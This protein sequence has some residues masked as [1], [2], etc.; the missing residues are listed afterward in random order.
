MS[1]YD[2]V[3]AK[4]WPT[5]VV[6]SKPYRFASLV[7]V[8]VS[9][10][11][12]VFSVVIISVMMLLLPKETIGHSAAANLSSQGTFIVFFLAVLFVPLYETLI[13]QLIPLELSRLARLNDLGCIVVG[14]AVFGLG[15]Y[16]NGGLLHGISALLGG[17]LFALS[18]IIL[19]PW[20]YL[21]A[22]WASY[23]AHAAHNGLM[24][25]AVPAI[26]PSLG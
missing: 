3:F 5:F 22:F 20:G 4:R 18:Y 15:H 17:S 24:L 21:P 13:A 12:V 8:V 16:L 1:A 9:L 26:F 6:D 10:V 2:W 11:S 7:G 23:V 19:R 25:Y 14:G